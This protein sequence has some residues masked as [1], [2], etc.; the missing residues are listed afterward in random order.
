MLK[1]EGKLISGQCY[2]DPT[3]IEKKRNK[4]M[5][6]YLSYKICNASSKAAEVTIGIDRKTHTHN[7]EHL[8]SRLL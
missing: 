6:F 1:G 2:S 3:C 7:I 5:L 8:Q 4:E